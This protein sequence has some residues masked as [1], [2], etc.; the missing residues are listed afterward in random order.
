MNN[1]YQ[2][3]IQMTVLSQWSDIK[4]LASLCINDTVVS[5][6]FLLGETTFNIITDY[7]P[8]GVHRLSINF[9]N[10]DYLA[11]EKFGQDTMIHVTNVQFEDFD[12]DFSI[13]SR[14]Q[15][16]Y[17]AEWYQ[18]QVDLKQTPE[19]EIHSNYLGWNG[20]WYL[21]FELPIYRWIHQKNNYGWL[22]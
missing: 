10:K 8:A 7:L 22:I 5:D 12:Y 21:D 17:P 2:T 1:R 18:Q 16:D 6:K 15:P 4:P 20:K 19:A 9:Q 11:F 14:Y 3:S 13:F